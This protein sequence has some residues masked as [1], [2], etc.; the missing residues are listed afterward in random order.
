MLDDDRAIRGLYRERMPLTRKILL[1]FPFKSVFRMYSTV[2]DTIYNE[3][4]GEYVD[5]IMYSIGIAKSN[6]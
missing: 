2:K 3:G 4:V 5:E 6:S 1:W